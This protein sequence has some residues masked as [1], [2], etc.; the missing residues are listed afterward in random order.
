MADNVLVRLNN[1]TV[2]T[3]LD[4]RCGIDYGNHAQLAQELDT[5]NGSITFLYVYGRVSMAL[6]PEP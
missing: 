1:L 5:S 4:G 6:Q 2:A 3:F